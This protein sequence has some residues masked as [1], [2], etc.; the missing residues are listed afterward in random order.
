[1]SQRTLDCCYLHNYCAAYSEEDPMVGEGTH[2]KDRLR[3]GTGIESL[4]PL[5][6]S[7]GRKGYGPCVAETA[8]FI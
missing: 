8:D 6:R 5:K 4:E 3:G 7:Q 1:M 2:G